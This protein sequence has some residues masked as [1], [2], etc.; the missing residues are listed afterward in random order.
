MMASVSG[1]EYRPQ[2]DQPGQGEGPKP[3][4]FA[5]G[6]QGAFGTVRKKE[7]EIAGDCQRRRRQQR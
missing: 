4:V 3:E 1:S 7:Y 5:K 6:P 2:D